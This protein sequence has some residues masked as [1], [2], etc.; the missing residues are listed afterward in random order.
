MTFS[1]SVLW[2]S[3]VQLALAFVMASIVRLVYVRFGTSLSNRR[4]FARNFFLLAM[5]ITFIISIVKSSLALSLGLVGALSIVRFRTPIKE[6]EELAYLF[7][8]IAIGIGL[9][10]NQIMLTC[11]AFIVII[12]AIVVHGLH[13]GTRPS[14]ESVNLSLRLEKAEAPSLEAIISALD[15]YCEAVVVRRFES[16]N[17][18]VEVGLQVAPHGNAAIEQMARAIGTLHP[19]AEVQFINPQTIAV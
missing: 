2:V 4:A 18:C 1:G 12:A 7:L 13:G 19:S 17:D 15:P 9:G 10:A 11:V 16:M 14:L 8:T 3:L 5:T 6:P